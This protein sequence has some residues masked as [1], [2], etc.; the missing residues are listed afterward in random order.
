LRS[1]DHPTATAFLNSHGQRVSLALRYCKPGEHVLAYG[2]G[3][4]QW[5]HVI[6][7]LTDRRFVFVEPAM[8]HN[9][10]V[11]ELGEFSLD[12]A[13]GVLTSTEGPLKPDPRSPFTA[14]EL[15][16]R[17]RHQG[18]FTPYVEVVAPGHLATA[19]PPSGVGESAA[20]PSRS[21]T[22]PIGE[23]ERLDALHR[24]GAIDD[25]EFAEL[26]RQLVWGDDGSKES[27]NQL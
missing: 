4:W 3:A 22:G 10:T 13:T 18:E 9:S 24:S 23:L 2:T 17:I 16:A 8:K 25:D 19:L 11:T 1:P 27:S 6:F 12:E 26:K 20:A 5:Q 14:H 21:A 15:D 7:L